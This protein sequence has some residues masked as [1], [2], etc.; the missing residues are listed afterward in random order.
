MPLRAPQHAAAQF[1]RPDVSPDGPLAHVA[2]EV[3][4]EPH[5]ATLIEALEGAAARGGTCV[6]LLDG[7]NESHPL[8]YADVLAGAHRWA[9]WLRNRGV[10]RGTKVVILL[11]TGE[12]FV[13]AFFGAQMAGGVP[14]PCAPP[15]T[16]G[17]L[18]KYVGNL[19]HIVRDCEAELFVTNKRFLK[20]V[21]GVV[22]DRNRVREVVLASDVTDEAP[23]VPGFPSLDGADTGF[24]QYTSGTTGRPKGV[25]LSH[26]NLLANAHGIG[27]GLGMSESDVGMSWLPLFHDMGLIGV[28]LTCLYW[29]FPV[30]VMAPEHFV[31]HPHRWL[32]NISR[33]RAT[34]SPAPNFAY[35]LCLRRVTEEQEARLDLSSWRVALNG[36]EPIDHG[37]VEQ[38]R[39]RF[40]KV[41]FGP[42]VLLPVYGMAENS[43]AATFPDIE[44]PYRS[45]PLDREALEQHRRAR[46]A[47]GSGLLPYHA[48]SVGYPLAGQEVAI[49]GD[50]GAILR[51]DQIGEIVVRGP[52]TT[53][54]YYQNEEETRRVLV[55]GWLHTGDL[56]F[57]SDRQLFVTGRKK[58]LIIQRG[59]NYYPYDIERVAAGVD[60]VRKGCLAAFA[61]PNPET[62]TE[63]IVLVAETHQKDR[64]GRDRIAREING[65]LLQ[66]LGVRADHVVLVPPKSVPKTSSG[67]V[68][69]AACRERFLDDALEASRLAATL[70]SAK[71]LVQSFLGN[72][73]HRLRRLTGTSE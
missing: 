17:A 54:G 52:S 28:L 10:A 12:D 51:E 26:G 3:P 27:L 16:F 44:D 13:F 18:E 69:R 62:G 73:A 4:C 56:G 60:G 22:G 42:K 48:V 67:K 59:R 19:K 47:N 24:L 68:Q 37:T 39:A 38:F 6:D 15:Y 45:R 50:D 11:P 46:K 32:E 1:R 41:G 8:S 43:L 70:G 49:L 14:V 30:H 21:G 71:T 61:S 29:R 2:N 33:F 55:D 7:R 40:S 5:S 66:A 53:S 31:L 36:A 35:H 57:L 25:V 65:A 64:E 23:R 20:A 9:V 58:D 34:L 72:Q 63:D